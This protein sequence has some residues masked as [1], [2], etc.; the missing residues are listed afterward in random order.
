MLK[1]SDNLKAIQNALKQELRGEED[2]SSR[3]REIAAKFT[4]MG[5]TDYS[6]ILTL[7]SQAEN[8]HRQVLGA[9]VD[10]IDLRCGQEVSSQKG[11]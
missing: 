5:E 3:Y 9:I 11:K 10:A 1:C 2:G 7:L 6:G 4:H 8:M